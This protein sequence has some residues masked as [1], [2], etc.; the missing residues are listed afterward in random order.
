MVVLQREQWPTECVYGRF[1]ATMRPSARRAPTM[2]ERASRRSRPWKGPGTVITACSSMTAMFGREWRWPISKSFGSCAG[3][4]LTAPV[5]NSGSTCSSATTGMVRSVS[6]SLICLPT[7]CLYR[8]SSGWT[9]TA[10]SPSIVSARVVATTMVSSPSPYF[11]E[12]SSPSSS[13]YSTSMSEIAV[14]QRGHQLM[15]RSAR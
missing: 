15:M 14:R 5:P 1:S 10:V 8:S 4:T 12:T 7:R 13:W 11:I 6:G 2:A 9:A 3:V